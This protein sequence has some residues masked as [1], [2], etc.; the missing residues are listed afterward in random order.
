MSEQSWKPTPERDYTNVICPYCHYCYVPESCDFDERER[1]ETC[2][3]CERQF[4]AY[5][6]FEVTHH[7][8]PLTEEKT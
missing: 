7:T 1:T 3:S 8:R 5:D 6:S 4:V 2:S